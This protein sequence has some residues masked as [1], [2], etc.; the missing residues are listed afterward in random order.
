[1]KGSK[2]THFGVTKQML[3]SFSSLGGDYKTLAA[4]KEGGSLETL[5]EWTVQVGNDHIREWWELSRGK[6]G[7]CK[8][9]GVAA[10]WNT[11]GACC[12]CVCTQAS[13]TLTQALGRVSAYLSSC[14]T[15]AELCLRCP[16]F[17]L[18]HCPPFGL[19]KKP[20]FSKD[21]GSFHRAHKILSVTGAFLEVWQAYPRS[22]I[23]RESLCLNL[24]VK[25][26]FQLASLLQAPTALSHFVMIAQACQNSSCKPYLNF[27]LLYLV[28]DFFHSLVLVLSFSC[29]HS[30][31]Q[32]QLHQFHA[33]SCS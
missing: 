5:G 13:S 24:K 28:M 11:K 2:P 26:L 9:K 8:W 3:L 30:W 18:G 33:Y 1:M 21:D 31:R 4:E 23:R 16:G 22:S 7:R 17:L 12:Q 19:V 25:R 14:K 20:S 6:E 15:L 27:L 32:K 10:L 29:A